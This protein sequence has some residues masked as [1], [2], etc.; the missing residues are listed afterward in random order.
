ML[1]RVVLSVTTA[2]VTGTAALAGLLLV[3]GNAYALTVSQAQLVDGQLRLDGA[4][5]APGIFVTVESASSAAGARS[6]SS[7]AYHVAASNFRS[8]DCKV[9]VSDRRTPIA[10]VTLAGCTPTAATP[11]SSTPP[12]TGSCVIDP[13]PPATRAAGAPTTFDFTTTGCDTT[14]GPVQWTLLGGHIPTGL[15]GPYFQGQT[16]GHLIG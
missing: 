10:T 14:N 16:A 12:P 3:P 13:Q 4:D 1:R 7:G 6:D 2:L 5:A 8:D 9:V 15:S 11:P